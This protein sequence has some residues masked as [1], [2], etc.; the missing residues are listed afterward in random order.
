MARMPSGARKITVE[1]ADGARVALRHQ[2]VTYMEGVTTDQKTEHQRRLRIP[3]VRR[4]TAVTGG[5][6]SPTAPAPPSVA[7]SFRRSLNG[8]FHGGG[9]GTQPHGATPIAQCDEVV[10]SKMPHVFAPV[11]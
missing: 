6:P 1:L 4:F 5:A 7:G 10:V 9:V 11:Y 2:T 3:A 8:G